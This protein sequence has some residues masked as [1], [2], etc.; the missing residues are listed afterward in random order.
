MSPRREKLTSPQTRVALA[1]GNRPAQHLLP[2]P[3]PVD[4]EAARRLF[5]AQRRRAV[6]TVVLLSVLLFG[7]SGA[8]A[9]FPQLSD[10]RV[11]QVPLSW[12]LLTAGLYPL[13]FG[14]ALWHMRSAERVEERAERERNGAVPT[15]PDR[16]ERP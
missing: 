2:I 3:E 7:V 16:G 9:A 12:L 5:R 13:L 6:R 10:V 4:T 15:A 11:A 8:F 14:L 1:R